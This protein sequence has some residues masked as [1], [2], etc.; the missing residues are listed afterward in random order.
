MHVARLAT[1]GE[2]ASGIAHELNQP[3]A[4]IATYAQA[5]DR[6]LSG[7][8][9]DVAEI[10]GALRQV[11]NQAVRAGDIIRRLRNLTRREE[12]R[13][14]SVDL[15]EVVMELT[16]LVQSDARAHGVTYRTVLAPGLPKVCI[17]S[18]QIQQVILNL[19]HN[20]LD[21]LTAVDRSGQEVIVSTQLTPEYDV[22]L[23]VCDTGPGVNADIVEKMFDPFCS[24]KPWGTGLGLPI[25]RTIVEAHAGSVSF[26][27]N[28][29][30]GACFSVRLPSAQS[31]RS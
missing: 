10:Q 15:N 30:A 29:P 25:S 19:V 22:Q 12:S 1:V 3:L 4:A 28:V 6:L 26:R 20:A 14:R 7:P 23:C 2:M 18:A 17:D 8:E 9:P 11:A 24:T 21:A 16:E 5:C 27:P 31:E 13:R